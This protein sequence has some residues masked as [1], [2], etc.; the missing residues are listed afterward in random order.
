MF[1]FLSDCRCCAGGTDDV[2]G[3]IGQDFAAW[4]GGAGFMIH[5][6]R[7][8]NVY[9]KLDSFMS[10]LVFRCLSHDDMGALLF[11]SV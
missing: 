9:L 7:R 3:A 2:G 8:C 4:L 6:I 1:R 10:E 5:S 11:S